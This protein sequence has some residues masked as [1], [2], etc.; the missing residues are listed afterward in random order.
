M[1]K[2]DQK[3]LEVKQLQTSFTSQGTEVVAVESLNFDLYRGEVLG[4]VGESGSGKSVS[5]LSLMKLLPPKRS[6]VSG[7]IIFE[8]INLAGLSESEIIAYR[9]KKMAMIFQEPMSSLNPTMKLGK[10]VLEMIEL[11]TDLRG[12]QAKQ[13]VLSLFEKVKLPNPERLYNAYAHQASGGQLQRVMIAMAISAN[14]DILIADEPTTALDVT[15][16]KEILELIKDIQKESN[17][18]TIFISH[19]LSLVRNLCDRVIVMHQ[20]KVVETGNVDEIFNHPT[21]AYTQGLIACRPQENFNLNRLPTVEDFLNGTVSKVAKKLREPST[22]IILEV[23]KLKK[24][25]PAKKNWLGKTVSY[26]KA[27]DEVG[28]K[29]VKGEI[30]GLVGES[31]CGKSTLGKMVTRL[32]D[33]DSGDIHYK[34]R[35]IT[36]IHGDALRAYRKEVQMIFQDP[37]GSLNP[38]MKIGE[39]IMEPMLSHKLHSAKAAKDRTYALLKKTGL[40]EEHFDR[41]PHEFSGGQRQ[42]VSIARALSLNP[43]LLVCDECISALD[44]SVQAQ[45]INLLLDLRDDLDLSI[46][47]IAHDLAAV[48][49]ISDQVAVMNSGKIVEKGS[50]EIVY[51]NPQN[52]YTKKL[53]NAIQI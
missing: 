16:Q 31:G 51:N 40:S 17:T 22:E 35:N 42:R 53:L 19:D 37:Y 8:G 12:G 7:K 48:R 41:Y 25:F 44:V 15:V 5:V 52:D 10:Q 34:G 9:G 1:V 6:V 38:R 45:I 26:T 14:P 32:I 20:G 30:L 43:E 3:I 18:A 46:L 27:V 49:F 21:H 13:R 24:Y 33:V 39:A 36:N 50:P 47:F 2:E 23:N 4:I 28:F 29:I 11:H